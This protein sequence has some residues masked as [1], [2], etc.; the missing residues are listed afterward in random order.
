VLGGLIG[1]LLAQGYEG[2]EATIQASLAL[3]SASKA[4]GGS[5]YAMLPTD[6][7]EEIGKL[8]KDSHII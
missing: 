5:S 2:L 7:I 8:E 3:T 4:Y 6:L 1:A